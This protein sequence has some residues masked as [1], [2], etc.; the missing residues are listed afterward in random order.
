[1]R[2]VERRATGEFLKVEVPSGVVVSVPAWMIDLHVC[3]ALKIGNPQV[4]LGALADLKRLVAL[5]HLIK[6]GILSA[7]QV[8]SGA[9]YQIRAEDIASET[10]K[11]AVA[12]KARPCRTLDTSTL[13]MF[14]DT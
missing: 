8:V 12:R 11:S 5:R 4:D 1:V 7:V 10:V 3:A 9:P 14:T 2:R 13:P 6:S